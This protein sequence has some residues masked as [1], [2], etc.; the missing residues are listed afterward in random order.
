[1][2]KQGGHEVIRSSN[3]TVTPV[4]PG[5]LRGSVQVGGGRLLLFSGW[6]AERSLKHR[7]DS[8]AIFVDGRQIFAAP[9]EELEPHRVFNYKGEFGFQ[10]ALPRR[11]LPKPGRP[12]ACAPSA[13]GAAWPRSCAPRSRT[14]GAGVDSVIAALSA[15]FIG[16][17]L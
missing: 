2:I 6:A 8:I 17:S 3:G 5:T 9:T 12:T 7:A 15:A 13:S 14:T 10:F 16:V 1:L 11:L 4:R